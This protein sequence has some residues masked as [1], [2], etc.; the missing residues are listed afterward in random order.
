MSGIGFTHDFVQDIIQVKAAGNVWQ[1]GSVLLLYP[2][3][4]HSV[5]VT[6]VEI[7]TKNAESIG[8]NLVPFFTRLNFHRQ[9]S[10]VDFV[11]PG[12]LSGLVFCYGIITA[13]AVNER[14]S[15]SAQGSVACTVE[16]LFRFFLVDTV[17]HDLIAGSVEQSFLHC[18]YDAVIPRLNG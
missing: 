14:F 1:Q 13:G 7:V 12:F 3:P 15:I 10:Q 6:H 5:Q 4:I 11:S 17:A 2:F 9:V 18:A 8:V 16:D